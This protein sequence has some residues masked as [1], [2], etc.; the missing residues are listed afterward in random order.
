[1]G[2]GRTFFTWAAPVALALAVSA[3]IASPARA[4]DA[5]ADIDAGEA[6]YAGLDYDKANLLAQ[7]VVA[8]H[9]LTHDQVVRAYRL[10]GRTYAVLGKSQQAIDSFEKLLT[11]A[12]DEKADKAQ[13]PRIQEA[14][15][16]AQGFWAGYPTKPGLE[17]T[18]VAL[19][20]GLPG[21][22]RVR[23][24]D[25]THQVKK[26]AVGY[27][28]GGTGNFSTT[29]LAPAETLNVDIPPGPAQTSRLD[30][31]AVALDGLDDQAFTVGDAATPKT[32]LAEMA[33]VGGGG[34][35]GDKSG[36]KSVFASP[37]FWIIAGAV[38]VGAGSAVAAVELKPK[39]KDVTLDPTA[40]NLNSALFC[41]SG[42]RCQ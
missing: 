19:R 34:G 4:A 17:A 33:P 8:V 39:A 3:T 15:S 9:G 30:Y 11:Y 13:T 5:S 27:R 21:T 38:I 2:K 1:M 12:P 29:E 18:T 40:A 28:W 20:V 37:V 16:E 24:H 10:L 35:G 7:K 31:Y 22:L 26:I 6:A 14:F 25:P 23:L 36:G 42:V 41:G 32:V